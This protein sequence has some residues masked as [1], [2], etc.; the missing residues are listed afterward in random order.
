[1]DSWKKEVITSKRTLKRKIPQISR[2]GKNFF[3]L[4]CFD[5]IYIEKIIINLGIQY[6][7]S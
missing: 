7:Q 6:F 5:L 3:C 1:M 2:N 4:F